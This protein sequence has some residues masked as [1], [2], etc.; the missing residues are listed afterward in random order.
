M[1]RQSGVIPLGR[2]GGGKRLTRVR[3]VKIQKGK[4]DR[5]AITMFLVKRDAL[6]LAKEIT[7]AWGKD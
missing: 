4:E 1:A 6:R 2:K 5:I 7:T 3:W